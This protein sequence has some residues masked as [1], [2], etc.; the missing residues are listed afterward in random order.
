MHKIIRILSI[1]LVLVM[2]A[3]CAAR[4][5]VVE[6]TATP[7]AA[8]TPEVTPTVAPTPTLRPLTEEEK[9]RVRDHGDKKQ[10][11]YMA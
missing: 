8:A 2:L 9:Q 6:P 4:Q 10:E 1:V 3:G 5:K 7:E 11:M